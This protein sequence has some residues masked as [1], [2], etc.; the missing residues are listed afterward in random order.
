M[1]YKNIENLVTEAKLGNK[2]AKEILAKEFTPFI[3]NL[4]E[5]TYIYS[6]EFSDIQ[7]ECYKALFK[8]IQTYSPERHRFVAYATNGIKNSINLLIRNSVRRASGDGPS[9]FILD[10]KYENILCSDLLEIDEILFK[11]AYK[12]KLEA[13]LKKL[14]PK[15]LE[16]IIYVYFKE[17]PLKKYARLK[18]INY[19]TAFSRKEAALDKLGAML[20]GF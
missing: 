13:S 3:L 12:T 2:K 1:D 16:L 14:K 15:E 20:K 17:Y 11:E 4:S 7:N 10:D 5:R 9:A 18:G 8:C 6:Y 19:S